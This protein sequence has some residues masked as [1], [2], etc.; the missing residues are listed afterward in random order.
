MKTIYI[1]IDPDLRRL[2]CALLLDDPPVRTVLAVFL[3]RNKTKQVGDGAVSAAVKIAELLVDDVLGYFIKNP[4]H[5]MDTITLIAESQSMQH[6]RFSKHKIDPDDILHLG[7]VIGVLM[8]SFSS[9]V[10]NLHLVQPVKWKKQMTKEIHHPRI[11]GHLKMP[12][13]KLTS[14]H[15]PEHHSELSQYSGDKVNPGD[16]SDINDSIGLA[17]YGAENKL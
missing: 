1:G 2:N 10:E 6:Q 9:V 17:L 15:Y 13:K 5:Q 8:G 3:R 4:Q 11:L 12:Y 7:Q 16:F 14:T